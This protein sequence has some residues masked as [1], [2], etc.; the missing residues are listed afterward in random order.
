[1]HNP[2]EGTINNKNNEEKWENHKYF[3]PFFVTNGIKR[4]REKSLF[5]INRLAVVVVNSQGA[6]SWHDFSRYEKLFIFEMLLGIR[7][8]IMKNGF[9]NEPQS[10]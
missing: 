1:M 9:V 10:V 7:G 2:N 4:E 8:K 6:K 3:S 5:F